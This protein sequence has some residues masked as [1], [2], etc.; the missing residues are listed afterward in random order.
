MAASA[1]LDSPPPLAGA[2]CLIDPP[3]LARLGFPN[4]FE[5]HVESHRVNIALLLIIQLSG[6]ASNASR[7]ECMPI[8]KCAVSGSST[9]AAV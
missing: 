3:P 1:R 9:L 5:V 6:K 2:V 8:L 4:R 7:C